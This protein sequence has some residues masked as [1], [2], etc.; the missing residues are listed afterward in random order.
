MKKVPFSEDEMQVKGRFLGPTEAFFDPPKKL[1]TPCTVEENL[2]AALKGEDYLWMPNLTDICNVQSR[3]NP[4]HIARAEIQDLGPKQ[5]DEEKGGPDLFGVKWQYVPVAMGSMEVPGEPHLLDD[6]NEWEEKVKWPDIDSFDW[7]GMAKLNAPFKEEE[8]LI[9]CTFQNGL[10]E[11]LISFMGFEEAV[12]ALIDEEQQDAVKALMDK[13][14]DMYIHFIGKYREAINVREVLFHDDWGSQRAPFF[15]VDTCMEMIVP[16]M[17]KISDYCH[18]NDMVFQLHSCGKNDLLVPAMVEAGV[19]LWWGQVMNDKD[20]LYEQFGDKIM[21][22]MDV[23]PIPMDS[24]RELIEKTAKEFVAKYT[25]YPAMA[26]AFMAPDGLM[27]E[28]YKQSRIALCG[29]AS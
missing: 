11:R 27:E 9:G 18:E 12:V 21:L 4:D 22:G 15:S 16:A 26:C 8:R 24:D 19:D 25:K 17:R 1:N 14:A 13:L 20:T 10:F 28:I 6:A 5:P 29:T 23:P 3:I 7:E 2:R